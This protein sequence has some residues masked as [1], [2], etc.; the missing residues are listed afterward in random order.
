MRTLHASGQTLEP[1][2]AA[3]AEAMFALLN[4]AAVYT[5]L[6]DAPPLSV[7]ALRE[8]FARLETRASADGSEQ[9]L[10]WAVRLD[11][12]ALAGFV[13]ATVCAGGRAW[14]AF[15]L[16]RA[17][18][19]QGHASRA[20][21]AVIDELIHHHGATRL[22]ATADRHNRRSIALLTR[23]GFAPA[24]DAWRAELDVAERDVLLA[25]TPSGN[26]PGRAGATA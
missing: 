19:G 9:W 17:F 2:T 23:L 14:L 15:V 6:D 20:T 7:L 26:P 21:Q 18:W 25:L 8:R 10:N 1:Q 22:L 11:G 3:H 16:G 4:D 5:Y 12:G 13:Q 24:P